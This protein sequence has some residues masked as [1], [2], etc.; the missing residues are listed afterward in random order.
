MR[1]LH[2]SFRF[3]MNAIMVNKTR[4]VLSLLGITIGIFC[5]ISVFTVF[6]SIERTIRGSVESLGSN[7]LFVQKWPWAMGG[8]YP[9]WKYIKRPEPTLLELNEIKRRSHA[10]EASAFTMAVNRS[11]S[12]NGNRIENAS[13]GGVSHEYSRVMALEIAEGRYFTP[14]ESAAGR[15][16]A[17]IGDNIRQNLFPDGEAIGQNITVW[18]RKLDVIG[19]LKREGNTPFGNSSDDQVL[20][21]VNFV[22]NFLDLRSG[23]VS[24]TIMVKAK[25]N[26]TNEELAAELTG[27]LR[28]VRR[29]HPGA[30]SSF[31]INETSLISKGFDALFNVISIVGWIIGGF[32]LLVGGFGIANIMFVSVKERT[33][34]IGIQKSV[35][36]KKW[37]I[38]IQYL[39]EAIFL[40]LLG[41]IIGL[42]IIYIGTLLFTH[43]LD[44][45][46]VLT[47]GNIILGVSVS[48]V[49]GLVSGFVPA[50]SASELDPVEAMRTTI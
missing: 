4:T 21:P 37:F 22:R 38:L 15:N 48:A 7:V 36:A 49:I 16:V 3:S 45:E 26:V 5:I 27:I 1:L 9:W 33:G 6:D 19:V 23:N 39:F 11:V 25:P 34:I 17:I 44:M 14:I 35:G 18:G 32:S 29:L 20:V 40:S 42:I 41:G 8:D 13:I 46:L 28:S 10:A 50:W 12:N 31:A 2:E 24:T 47:A 43:L 30:E